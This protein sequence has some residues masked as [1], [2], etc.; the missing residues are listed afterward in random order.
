MGEILNGLRGP[1][2]D[3]CGVSS[4]RC[5]ELDAVATQSV[6]AKRRKAEELKQLRQANRPK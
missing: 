4:F 6:R 3:H 2:K 1:H 5:G